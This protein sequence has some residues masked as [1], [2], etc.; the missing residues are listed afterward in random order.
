MSQ[1][2]LTDWGALKIQMDH[3]LSLDGWDSSLLESHYLLMEGYDLI[4]A[5]D[6]RAFILRYS[7]LWFVI[8]TFSRSDLL[9]LK[10]PEKINLNPYI[11]VFIYQA[12]RLY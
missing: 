12:S 6:K 3:Q 9:I 7:Q 1:S 4:M 2:D 10:E 5:E 11:N 8:S